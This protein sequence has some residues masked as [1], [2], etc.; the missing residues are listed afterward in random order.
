MF[1]AYGLAQNSRSLLDICSSANC[2]IRKLR[3]IYIQLLDELRE[4]GPL[5]LATIIETKGS[6]PQI[7][8]ASALFSS[9][10][11]CA[12]TVGGGLLEAD[13][14]RKALQALQQSVSLLYK[15]NLTADISSA[16]GAI[17][18]GEA[19]I[20][21]DVSP[22]DHIEVFRSISK[23]LGQRQP[24]VL[25][26]F[27]CRYSAEKISLARYWIE[28]GEDSAVDSEM[29]YARFHE[30]I[31]KSLIESRPNLL[32]IEEMTLFENARETFLFVE[33]IYPL[34]HLIIA[35][36]GHIGQAVSHL[37]SLLD[38]E[39]TVIDDRPEFASKERLPEAD[40]IIVDDIGKA[41][42]AVP[43]SSDTYIVI[44]TRGHEKD[45]DALRQCIDSQAAY[46]GMIGSARKIKLMRERFLQE[47]LATS[48]QWDR[49]Y[50]PIGIEIQSKTVQE[51]AVSIAA[52]LVLV[53]RQNQAFGKSLE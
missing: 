33:P 53:R 46:V 45:A 37:G 19:T 40:N 16:E 43:I 44:V 15:F 23:S 5:A 7:P 35:G 4:N 26:T 48:A 49:I 20:L 1:P 17:C 8:G 14:Q 36:A 25:A 3:N 6:T 22:E 21:M 11:L 52:Q 29:S 41:M 47:G 2:G 31:R 39:V 34:P 13:A 24:G 27:I 38:F 42:Q 9:G 30:E 12:G 28:M 50:A 18:G 10:G 51:I 32:K